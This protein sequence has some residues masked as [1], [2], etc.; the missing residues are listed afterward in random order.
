MRVLAV[1]L[2]GRELARHGGGAPGLVASPTFQDAGT[3]GVLA[4]AT[5]PVPSM[6]LATFDAAEIEK[7]GL[8]Y[9]ASQAVS[10]DESATS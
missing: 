1:A 4:D 7:R 10:T 5:A 2:M 9:H 6:C 8:R 3:A